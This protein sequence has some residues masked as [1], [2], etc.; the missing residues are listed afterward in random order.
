MSRARL[1]DDWN[2]VGAWTRAVVARRVLVLAAVG[3][4]S[5]ELVRDQIIP[6]TLSTTVT[7]WVTVALNVAG[8]IAGALWAHNGS[9]PADP[10]KQPQDIYGNKL[11]SELTA[12]P[13][14]G[15][16]AVLDVPDVTVA[17]AAAEQ[18]HPAGA[19]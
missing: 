6:L 17:F 11:V 9:T 2:K 14:P 7:H 12:G 13:H 16:P 18:I 5:G 10:L 4:V 19:A 15:A 3:A 1:K 8:V